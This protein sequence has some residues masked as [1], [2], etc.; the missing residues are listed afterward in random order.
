M[1]EFRDWIANWLFARAWSTCFVIKSIWTICTLVFELHVLWHGMNMCVHNS[2]RLFPVN[3]APSFCV[4]KI[5]VFGAKHVYLESKLLA[6][7]AP[8]LLLRVMQ[9]LCIVISALQ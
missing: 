4:S 7:R 8:T 3:L 6:P 5:V 2:V 9:S 1:N